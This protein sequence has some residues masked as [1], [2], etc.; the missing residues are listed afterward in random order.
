MDKTSASLQKHLIQTKS[1]QKIKETFK[2]I[3][4]IAIAMNCVIIFSRFFD[5][6][7]IFHNHEKLM[8]N[9]RFLLWV[10]MCYDILINHL[11][12]S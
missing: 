9:I 5:E 8:A 10:N 2:M 12:R 11:P 3:K 1:D 7:F 6:K 4:N